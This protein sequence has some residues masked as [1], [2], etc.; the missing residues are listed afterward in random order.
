MAMCSFRLF[1][2]RLPPRPHPIR[3]AARSRPLAALA[4]WLA[5]ARCLLSPHPASAII[6]VGALDTPGWASDVEVVGGL[7][8]VADGSSGLRVIDVSNPAAPVEL[9]ALDT[10]GGALN[11]EVVGGLAYVADYDSGLRVIDVSNP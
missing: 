3:R 4:F 8:Y 1:N 10:P 5:V 11:V 6:N 7:A 9:G 2:D